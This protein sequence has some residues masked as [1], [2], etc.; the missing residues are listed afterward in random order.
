MR[1]N[2]NGQFETNRSQVDSTHFVSDCAEE[3]QSNSTLLASLLFQMNEEQRKHF[4]QST[5]LNG[6]AYINRI[7]SLDQPVV[8]KLTDKVHK[9]WEELQQPNNDC[10]NVS[11]GENK[12]IL[13]SL[14]PL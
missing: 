10:N 1:A 6:I 12:T 14:S 3:N 8:L 13:E 2:P 9:Q 11:D 7:P 5:E 4:F